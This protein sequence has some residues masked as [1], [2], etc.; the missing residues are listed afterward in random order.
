MLWPAA[1]V[2]ARWLLRTAPAWLP[3]A[4]EP[5]NCRLLELGA[6]IGLTGLASAQVVGSVCLTD[7]QSAVLANLEYNAALVSDSSSAARTS[8]ATPLPP[9]HKVEVSHLDWMKLE[10][11]P[12]LFDVII[13]SDI[14]CSDAAGVAAAAAVTHHLALHGRA[15]FLLPPPH[16]RFGVTSFLE[17]L[18]KQGLEVETVGVSEEDVEGGED[19]E[20]VTV[21]GGYEASLLLHSVR[22]P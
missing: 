7:F 1:R 4:I 6:G 18:V 17:S 3:T 19:E 13:G 5:V 14:V 22:W 10:D 9:G 16:V 20:E 2:L 12:D 11:N 8:E 15:Y 21:G